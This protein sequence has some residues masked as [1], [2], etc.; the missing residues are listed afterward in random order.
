MILIWIALYGIYMKIKNALIAMKIFQEAQLM[1]KPA[2]TAD[3]Y[4]QL[5]TKTIDKVI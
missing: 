5:N 3:M 4:S 1:A 2:I